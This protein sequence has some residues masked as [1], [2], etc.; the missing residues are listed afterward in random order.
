[1]RRSTSVRICLLAAIASLATG[2][3]TYCSATDAKLSKLQRGMTYAETA[4]VMG[5]NGW[6]VSRASVASGDFATVEW[7]GP[8][9][10]PSPRAQMDFQDG[11]LLS[12]TTGRRFGL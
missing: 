3:A 11:R 8:G 5:C 4:E 10:R 6:Q 12:F 7:D 9:P 1:M 2:C